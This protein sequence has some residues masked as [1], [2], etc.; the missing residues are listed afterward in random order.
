MVSS[1]RGPCVHDA[2]WLQGC[3]IHIF[4]SNATWFWNKKHFFLM[5]QETSTSFLYGLEYNFEG[6]KQLIP[7]F[8]TTQNTQDNAKQIMTYSSTI[9]PCTTGLLGKRRQEGWNTLKDFFVFWALWCCHVDG[10]A[11][12]DV[13]QFV[14]KPCPCS[15][16]MFPSPICWYLAFCHSASLFWWWWCPA[17]MPICRIQRRAATLLKSG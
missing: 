3:F 10:L 15:L 12:G 2:V 9:D 1:L 5:L 8:D 11:V 7:G 13:W 16:E 4:W 14:L 17:G 6:G